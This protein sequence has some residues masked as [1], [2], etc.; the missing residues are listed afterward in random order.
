MVKCSNY[1]KLFNL[2]LTF[3]NVAPKTTNSTKTV[4]MFSKNRAYDDSY[5]MHNMFLLL[6]QAAQFEF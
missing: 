6:T 3:F 4:L 5:G 2:F 1:F